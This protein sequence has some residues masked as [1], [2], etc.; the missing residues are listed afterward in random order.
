MIQRVQ[1]L[2]LLAIVAISCLLIFSDIDFY[3]ETGKPFETDEKTGE[4]IEYEVTTITVDYNSTQITEAPVSKNESLIYFLSAIAVLAF[5]TIFMYK[6]RKLQLRLA[7][8]VI[9][10]VIVV[11]VAMYLISF[12]I[13]Y[14]M[15]DSKKSIL[16]GAFIPLALLVFGLLSYKRIQKDEKLVRSLDRIR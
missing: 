9:V 15:L 1:S 12:G 8:G 5:V 14:P 4:T 16:G 7:F 10:L 11:F 2:Y 6:K 13:E 3:K